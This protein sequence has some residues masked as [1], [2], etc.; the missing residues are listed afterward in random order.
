MGALEVT[1]FALDPSCRVVDGGRVLLG[2]SPLTLFR[3]GPGGI[4]VVDAIRSG[5]APAAGHERLTDRLVESGAAHPQPRPGSGPARTEVTLVIPAYGAPP[6][7]LAAL[8]RCTG[9]GAAVVVDDASTR[10]IDAVAG[11]TVVRLERNHGPGAA[12]QAGVALATTPYVAFLDT[13]TLPSSAWLDALLPHFTDER[14]GLV[15]PRI[16][17]TPGRGLLARYERW[18]SPLDLGPA[19]ARVRSGTRISYVP[20]AAVVVRIAALTAVGGF[21]ATLRFGEDVDLVWRLDAAGWRVRY[22]PASTVLHDPRPSFGEWARQRFNYGSSAAPLADRHPGA[23]APA[24]MN[25]WSAAAWGVGVVAP[26]AGVAIAA[27]TTAMLAR[28]LATLQHPWRIAGRLAGL[29]H[30]FAGRILAAALVRAWFP[31]AVIAAL[32]SRRARL[33]TGVA[34]VAPPL[35]AW[36]RDRPEI[37]PVRAIGLHIADDLAYGAGLW[38]GMA[39]ARSLAAIRPV[40]TT[41]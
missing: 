22:E 19:P 20:A 40:L 30:L 28:K 8:V 23:L 11:A 10:P 36:I 26:P 32:M 7:R 37:D 33:I 25:R 27:A 21:D 5:R 15:A 1:R 9:A 3:L 29:G 31:F 6:A 12:R 39:R 24:R 38:R 2:G 4:D 35:V 41:G 17:S 18:R 16:R 14:V 34:V 13:D